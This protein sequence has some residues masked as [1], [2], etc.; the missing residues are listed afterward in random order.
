MEGGVLVNQ[1][2]WLAESSP[3][4]PRP[5]PGPSLLPLLPLSQPSCLCVQPGH[6]KSS[7][8]RETLCWLFP[9]PG[10]SSQAF[11]PPPPSPPSRL[12]PIVTSSKM[13]FLTSLPFFILIPPFGEHLSLLEMILSTVDLC[14]C[15]NV[16]ARGQGLTCFPPWVPNAAP[17]P[18]H[19]TP[20]C[21]VR[22]MRYIG[23]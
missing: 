14:P 2:F 1:R 10:L 3:T 15:W 23:S 11:P 22:Y 12:G 16:R 18:R 5:P 20:C 4:F 7:P 13:P 19:R 6:V 9:V 8:A 17:S 21:L